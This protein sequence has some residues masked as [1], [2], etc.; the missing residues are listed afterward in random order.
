MQSSARSWAA[1]AVAV[2]A[3]GLAGLA[4]VLLVM[5]RPPIDANLWFFVVDVTVACVYGTIAAVTLRRRRHP[6]PILLAV[7][8]VG[9]GLAAFGYAFAVY[10]MQAGF[11]PAEMIVRLQSTAW[12]PGTLAL[13]LVVPWLVRDH[14]LGWAW[15]GLIVGSAV[16]IVFTATNFGWLGLAAEPIVWASVV[17]G[18]VTA[19]ETEWRHLRGP[20]EERNGLG[21]LALGT[22]ILAVSF[23]PLVVDLGVPFWAT[24]ILHLLSQAVF[25][26]AVL[27]AVLRNRM[28]GLGLAVSRTTLVAVL[29]AGLIGVYL[30]IFW[31]LQRLLPEGGAALVAA[32]GVAVAVQPLRLYLTRRVHTLVY[33]A[34]ADPSGVVQRLGSHLGAAGSAEEL[35][36]GLAE[37]IGRS[38]RLESVRISVPDTADL[39][40]GR[41]T[42]LPESIPLVHRGEG[43]GNLEVTAPPGEALDARAQETLR[44]LAAVVATA[45]AV[46][47]AAASVEDMRERVARA[48]LEERR[49]IR[50]EIHDGLGPSLAGLRL[51]LQGARNL[52]DRDPTAAQQLLATLQ[53]ELDQRVDA[54][55]SL[56]HHLLPPVLDELGL[57]AALAELAARTGEAGLSVELET[58]N[59][60]AVPTPVAAA[61]YGITTE[62]LANVNRHAG[63]TR[64]WVTARIDDHALTVSIADDGR[65]IAPDARPGVGSR[66]MRERA[67]EQGGSL[68]LQAATSAGRGTVV[69]A[70]LPIGARP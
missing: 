56:S 63:A 55:R 31:L 52:L 66:S 3:W 34:A 30:V 69:T 13:Y 67:E 14:P 36:A 41:P 10:A 1:T 47:R 40:W 51:G 17:V 27:V 28:W 45:V 22:A 2:L 60:D 21:W 18:L 4:V 26:A 38:M 43:V 61:A 39:S 57:G 68:H 16:T 46:A 7:A 33:G 65:G 48:R 29:S 20:V 37:D 62:A 53:T 19:A 15:L 35:L 6:V 49:M 11:Q 24:P 70:R 44:D 54:V 42:S 59:L 58:H 9:G 32:A 5:G 25:P 50:R 12:V 8:A 23:V 64:A